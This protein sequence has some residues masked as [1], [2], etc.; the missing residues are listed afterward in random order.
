MVEPPPRAGDAPPVPTELSYFSVPVDFDAAILKNAVEQAV[1]RT[2]WTINRHFDRCVLSQKVKLFGKK[3][4]V[5]PKLGC[6]VVGKVTR[7]PIR[8]SGKGRD[9]LAEMPL[10]ATV[11]ARDIGGVLKG[12][13]A[14]GAATAYAV[15]R[16][17]VAPDWTPKG[18]V[19]L[20][21]AWTKPPG[22]DFLGQRITFTDKADQALKP[23][24]RKLERSLPGELAKLQLRPKAEAVW[25][26]A[27]T[28][29]KLNGEKPPVWMRLTPKKP[30]FDGYSLQNGTIRLQVGLEATTETFVG[31]RP[32][33]PEPVPLPALERSSGQ[34]A[35][36][37]FIPVIAQ[38]EQLQPVVARAL[39]KRATRP[40][41]VPGLG[42][43]D[44]QFG[45][46]EV[47]GTPEGRIAVGMDI[48]AKLRSRGG[49]PTRGRI[50]LTALPVNAENSAEVEFANLHVTGDTDGV[51]GDL[52]LKFA[53][54]PS[55]SQTI[56]GALGQNFS[57]DLDGLLVKVRTAI[58]D[59]RQGDFRIEADIKDVE[60][61]RLTAYGQGLYLAVRASG[62]AQV[63]YLPRR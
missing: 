3:L 35:L 45:E 54:T 6:D 10:R 7:G 38:Y 25:N 61:G 34:Q 63:T 32:P 27:F 23:V 33:D 60:T 56:G 52:L 31:E 26:S 17:D 19:S 62:Q 48:A 15:I 11:S 57:K 1:P 2:L 29:L 59:T 22:I 55:L 37:F 40:F 12:E 50:W 43:V 49:E 51:G 58:V 44:A 9:I 28:S 36:R 41:A 21:Y 39:A 42:D 30:V 5:T 46:V 16:L 24:V 4:P 47:Y 53:S 8:L 13:T 14:T 20:R 18:T